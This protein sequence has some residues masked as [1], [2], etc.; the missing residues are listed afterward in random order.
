MGKCRSGC[1][2]PGDRDY[3]AP[4]RY[5]CATAAYVL[6]YSQILRYILHGK[7]KRRMRYYIYC[8]ESVKRGAKFSD[9]YGGVILR[10]TDFESVAKTLEELKRELGVWDEIK[11]Q[12]VDALRAER[13]QR[14]VGQFFDLIEEEKIR[15]R[16]M[17]T[18]NKN[19][20]IGRSP[21]KTEYHELHRFHLLYY[22]FLKH[23]FGL[24]YIA[25]ETQAE[26][27]DLEIFLDKIPDTEQKNEVFKNFLYSL[28]SLPG[29]E[30]LAIRRDAIEEIDSSKHVIVQCL[31]VVLGSMAFRLNE[32][33]KEKP[34]GS[35]TRG[36]R[37]IAKEKIYKYILYRIQSLYP[38][39]NIGITTGLQGNYENL[40]L[41]PYRH[42]NFLPNNWKEAEQ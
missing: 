21:H 11:W 1:V 33:H 41:H 42:W 20:P 29:Y 24:K 22:Q 14:I 23:A 12:K 13:Y 34:V 4:Q 2:R 9:F 27:I 19:I 17:F 10:A 25:Q 35:R 40:W 32:L 5:L 37:T 30:A 8:D 3:G 39:F 26:K 36:K 31:D 16:I 28:Q 7:A 6:L 18:Q 38:H 15:M